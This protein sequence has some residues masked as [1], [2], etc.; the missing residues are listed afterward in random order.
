MNQLAHTLRRP[1]FA[2]W[3]V[4]II[5]LAVLVILLSL[6]VRNDPTPSQDVRVLEWMAGWDVPGLTPFMEAVSLITEKWPA[7]GLAVAGIAAFLGDFTLGEIVGRSRPLEPDTNTSFP[8]GHV[9]G[10]MVFFGVLGFVAI[11]YRLNTKLLIP[12]LLLIVAF[13]VAVGISRIHL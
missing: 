2:A 1:K 8:S 3:L 9:F 4:S 5:G 12:F 7:L 13:I 6:A 10:S 11:Y